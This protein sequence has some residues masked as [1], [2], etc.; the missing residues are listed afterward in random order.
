MLSRVGDLVLVRD[1]VPTQLYYKFDVDFLNIVPSIKSDIIID[2]DVSSYNGIEVVKSL[3]DGNYNIVGVGTTTF[4]YSI[5]DVPDVSLYNSSNSICKYTTN[6][7]S[8][9]GPI[10]KINV[11][12]GGTGY[13]ESW[14]YFNKKWYW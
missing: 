10:A 13:K 6:S 11:T 9:F 7:R 8:V 5:K 4:E 1:S 12:D 14:Y 2:E 3:Y